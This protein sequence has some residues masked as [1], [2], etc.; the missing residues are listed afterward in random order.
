MPIIIN[1]K[2]ESD[3]RKTIIIGD[4][5]GCLDEFNELL[6]LIEYDKNKIRLISVGDLIDR[7]PYSVEC[8]R[9][10]HD[11]GIECL[12]AN[13]ELK[14]LKFF[15]NHANDEN[16]PYNS[17]NLFY[18][19]FNNEDLVYLKHLPSHIKINKTL[20]V[21]AGL[22]PNIILEKQE[23][24]DLLHIRFID[25]NYRQVSLRKINEFG[26]EATNAIFWT[27][28]MEFPEFDKIIYGHYVS[29]LTVP[30]YS[31]IKNTEFFGID[32]GCVFG[33]YLT[34]IDIETNQIFQVKA[35]KEYVKA[36]YIV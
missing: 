17:G 28:F 30:K 1:E 22:K 3:N 32:T 14:C 31:K 29:S 9:R 23:F 20:I 8:V 25:K 26:K 15:K 36:G 33:G 18:K 21:H 5:H 13:H 16:P 2:L 6:E 11:L 10:I 19:N 27:D 34:A 24:N 4:I 35:H 7:G 12:I